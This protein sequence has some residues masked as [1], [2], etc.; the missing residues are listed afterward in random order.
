MQKIN[1]EQLQEVLNYCDIQEKSILLLMFETGMS[2][3]DICRLNY[4]DF[5]ISLSE[6]SPDEEVSPYL[7]DILMKTRC[8]YD[9][10]GEFE[11]EDVGGNPYKIYCTDICIH[12]L[13]DWLYVR[14]GPEYVV[15]EQPLFLGFPNRTRITTTHI[16]S[17]FRR[18]Q[19][20]SGVPLEPVDLR[21]LY[22]DNLLSVGVPVDD[23][24]FYLGFDFNP[25][26][27]IEKKSMK[28][29]YIDALKKL[30]SNQRNKVCMEDHRY[31][32][33]EIRSKLPYGLI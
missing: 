13:I 23:I 8:R 16:T 30:S 21:R 24:M 25:D 29:N 3:N 10:I 12:S 5:L 32:L 2:V 11:M 22:F 4:E 20:E 14:S 17:I 33:D 6:Y 19:Y 26:I 31:Y 18:L 15:F 28:D 1:K 7:D 27:Y 9:I